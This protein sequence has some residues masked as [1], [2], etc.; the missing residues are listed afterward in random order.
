M[1]KIF[2]LLFIGF[3]VALSAQTETVKAD[4]RLYDVYEA[5][6]L[7]RL[8]TKNP[9]LIQRWNF[10]LDNAWRLTRIPQGKD[11]EYPTV[12]VADVDNINILLLQKEQNL[13]R[14]FNKRLRYRIAGTDTLIEYYSGKEFVKAFNA[15][16]GRSHAG[17]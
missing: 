9:A 7:N 10:Y 16:T 2:L 1:K 13:T 17:E 15:H 8:Q 14:D 3:S 4:A 5:D 12:S 6:Y 11:G